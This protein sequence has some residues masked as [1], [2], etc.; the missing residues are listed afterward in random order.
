MLKELYDIKKG[1]PKKDQPRE[2]ALAQETIE[3]IKEE[4][5]SDK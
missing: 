1:K 2:A 5:K 3:K 4:R